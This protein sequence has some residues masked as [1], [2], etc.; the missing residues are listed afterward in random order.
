MMQ[1]ALGL[2]ISKKILKTKFKIHTKHQNSKIDK[3]MKNVKKVAEFFINYE[4]I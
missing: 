1:N 2:K 4:I 3:K